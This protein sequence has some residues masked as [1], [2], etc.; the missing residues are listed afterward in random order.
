MKKNTAFILLIILCTAV[1]AGCSNASKRGTEEDILQED[2][3]DNSGPAEDAPAAMEHD[4]VIIASDGGNTCSSTIPVE[5]DKAFES[6]KPDQQIQQELEN[7]AHTFEDPL[8]ILNPF[9]NSPLTAVVLFQTDGICAVS[10][11]VEGDTDAADVTGSVKPARLH[12][13]PVIG[14]YPDKENK[15][16]LKLLDEAGQIT[17][18]TTIMIKTDPLPSSMKDLVKVEKNTAPSAYGLIEASGFDTPHPFAFDTQGKVRWYLSD[19]YASYGYFP[20]SNNHF[21]VMDKDVMTPTSEKPHS[22]QLY[23]MDYMGRVDQIYMIENGA[24]H[25]IIEKTPGGNLLVLTNSIDG[26]VED[27]VQEID[28]ETGEIIKSLDMRQIFGDTYVDMVDWAHLNTVSYN[29]ETDSILISV[30]NLHS[31]IKVNWSTDELVWILGNPEFW[32]DTPFEE[33]VL[34]PEGDIIWN[35]QQHSVYEIPEDLDNDPDTLQIMMYDNHWDKTRDVDFFDNLKHSYVSLFI[36]NE[37]DGTVSQLHTYEGIKSK[38]TSNFSFDYEAGRVFSMGAYLAEETEDGRNGII[39]EYDY[40][41]EELLNQYSLRYT[42][43]RAYEFVPDYDT[44]AVPLELT[45]NYF[46]GTLRAASLNTQA[47]AAPSNILEKGLSCSIVRQILYLK[48]GDHK[49]SRVEFIG[50][51]NSY[52]LD[53][54]YAGKG[55]A[56]YKKLTYDIAV[57]FSNLEPD[58]YQLVVT[59]DGERYNTG[60]TLTIG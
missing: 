30:R 36:V 9:G 26:H 35:Y 52:M 39:G 31:A 2:R 49:I 19:S 1:F 15:V 43:Y 55:E 50:A 3:E 46:K 57:P 48:A 51:K 27:M 12:R 10:V 8:T 22:Q 60:E 42:F 23:E 11:T 7:K 56:S 4:R 5:E 53:L 54:A 25:E 33:K 13:V 24:H 41:S 32:K 34:Q 18:Q 40:E 37:N 59:Y 45:G 58:E 20:L 16:T 21:I 47:D 28:R 14:L 17:D 29:E 6:Y 38:I 44:C